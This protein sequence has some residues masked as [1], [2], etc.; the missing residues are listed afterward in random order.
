MKT[1]RRKNCYCGTVLPQGG[2]QQAFEHRIIENLGKEH[3]TRLITPMCDSCI[4][5]LKVILKQ[6]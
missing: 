6:N 5:E 3:L 2:Y 1:F 4:R